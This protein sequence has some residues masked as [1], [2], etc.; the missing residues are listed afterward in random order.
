MR[1]TAPT[2]PTSSWLL[3]M[4]AWS[5]S[6]STASYRSPGVSPP[7]AHRQAEERGPIA[8]RREARSAN[9]PRQQ[10][11]TLME[12]AR[13]LEISQLSIAFPNSPVPV[14]RQVDL[15]IVRGEYV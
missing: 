1:G 3:P 2:S 7:A 13:F 9:R 8:Q 5:A 12:N 4:S 6:R 14:L 11:V 10:R 15:Q